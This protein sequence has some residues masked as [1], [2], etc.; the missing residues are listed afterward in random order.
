MQNDQKPLSRNR[1]GDLTFK[2]NRSINGLG[3]LS[4]AVVLSLPSE[5]FVAV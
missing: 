2:P 5:V 1:C 3:G 4:S